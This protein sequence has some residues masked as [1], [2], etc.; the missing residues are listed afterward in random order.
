[1]CLYEAAARAAPR[2]EHP[3]TVPSEVCRRFPRLLFLEERK[4]YPNIPGGRRGGGMQAL[5]VARTSSTETAPADFHPRARVGN[6]EIT[7]WPI[8]VRKRPQGRV[9]KGRT[10]QMEG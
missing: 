6:R 4:L 1:M 5:A 2:S 3:E 7:L 9:S 8:R 10:E